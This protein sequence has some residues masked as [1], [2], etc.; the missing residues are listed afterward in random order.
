[1]TLFGARER[2]D[3]RRT[4]EHDLKT[5][6]A[7]IA[8][9]AEL[10]RD[11]NDERTRSEAIKRIL[12]GVERLRSELDA[13]AAR[14]TDA[15]TPGEGDRRLRRILLVDDDDDLRR[16]LHA[17]F[18]EDDFEL[19]DA[20]DGERALALVDEHAP[21]LVVLDWQLPGRSGSEVLQRLKTRSPAPRV[22]VLT[23]DPNAAADAGEAD[24]F[25]TKPFSPLQL[26]SEI[27]RL[28]GG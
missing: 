4:V 11:R 26:L 17:T 5:P 21:E 3:V 19:L 16:L 20:A 27:E 9:Y 24:A 23:A 7:V 13:L 8:G 25:V 6:L 1:V 14:L 2:E 18:A 28:L 15:P 10:L 22:I 12:E